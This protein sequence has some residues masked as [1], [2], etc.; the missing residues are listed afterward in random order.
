M[1]NRKQKSV[2]FLEESLSIHFTQEQ[3]MQFIGLFI[4]AKQL[5]RQEIID[6]YKSGS[7]YRATTQEAEQYYLENYED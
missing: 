7:D 4:Q 3:Q 5:N 2:E 6:A 1:S